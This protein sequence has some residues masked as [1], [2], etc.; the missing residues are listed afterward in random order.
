QNR[1]LHPDL[2]LQGYTALNETYR[3]G[4]ALELSLFWCA[5]KAP[6]QDMS[7]RLQL[8]DSAGMV[9]ATSE[10]S[11]GRTNFPSGQWTAG[12]LVMD[13]ARLTVPGT[14]TAEPH[15]LRL[16]LITE[17]GETAVPS[18]YRWLGRAETTL[19]QVTVVPWPF[20][21]E[22]PPIAT[23]YEAEWGRPTLLSLQGYDLTPVEPG[24]VL[25][26]TLYWRGQ[27]E[28]IEDNY[29]V[30]IHIVDNTG[31]IVAQG[32]GPPVNGFRPTSSWRLGE[33]LVDERAIWLP[34]DLA[35]AEYDIYLGLYRPDT[36]ERLPVFQ[37]GIMQPDGRLWLGRFTPGEQE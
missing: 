23:A 17:E 33:A 20:V 35:V 25:P 11:L 26:L 5:E 2:S 27:S 7:L 19:A 24:A 30:F 29:L 28:A 37:E 15:T 14:A 8:V 32:D 34:P 18:L 1:R 4:H 31:A 3:P 12:Q 16:S 9:I 13:R 36:G 21:A 22:F 10:Q 6:G